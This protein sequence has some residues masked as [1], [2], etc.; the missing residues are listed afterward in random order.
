MT[1]T[2]TDITRRQL[3]QR[4]IE[5][6]YIAYMYLKRNPYNFIKK[7]QLK[8]HYLCEEDELHIAYHYYIEL[9][10]VHNNNKICKYMIDNAGGDRLRYYKHKYNPKQI[11][12][13]PIKELKRHYIT[14]NAEKVVAVIN[15]DIKFLT[16]FL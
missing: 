9:D 14:L 16:K 7:F 3:K 8:R 6:A 1:E 11:K 15:E 5:Y 13:T 4:C 2:E 10:V 12:K